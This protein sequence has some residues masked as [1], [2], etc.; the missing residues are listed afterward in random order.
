MKVPLPA[1]G[2]LSRLMSLL[3]EA[4][5]GGLEG[6]TDEEGEGT[7]AQEPIYTEN[8]SDLPQAQIAKLHVY[9]RRAIDNIAV[10]LS[11]NAGKK[12][13]GGDSRKAVASIPREKPTMVS[14][15]QLFIRMF[16]CVV[17]IMLHWMPTYPLDN[18]AP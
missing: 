3:T 4:V 12:V 13:P 11:R 18:C 10:R 9:L 2:E 5:D 17:A 8:S 1:N 16:R 15:G 14:G 7:V 6:A